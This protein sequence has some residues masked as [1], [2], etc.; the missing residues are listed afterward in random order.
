MSDAS[1]LSWVTIEAIETFINMDFSDV[2][3]H[4]AHPN[5]NQFKTTA[6]VKYQE[7][8]HFLKSVIF[9]GVMRAAKSFMLA[10]CTRHEDAQVKVI[11]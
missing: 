9:F 7:D 11:F 4:G 8:Y 3:V 10:K 1:R 5:Q 2:I 6:E